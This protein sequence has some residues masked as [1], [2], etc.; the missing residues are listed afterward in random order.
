MT[1]QVYH[2]MHRK[3]KKITWQCI[4][5]TGEFIV[6]PLN[7]ELFESEKTEEAVWGK[8]RDTVALIK[9]HI[10]AFDLRKT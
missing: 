1:S 2:T 4:I 3:N 8:S 10:E 5:H 7:T 6:L 9:G